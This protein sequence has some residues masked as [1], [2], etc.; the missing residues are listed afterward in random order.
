MTLNDSLLDFY[1]PAFLKGLHVYKGKDYS[2]E[3]KISDL[4]YQITK[5]MPTMQIL[6]IIYWVTLLRKSQ[7]AH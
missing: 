4:L 7:N 3:L 6:T 1:E 2:C 5:R